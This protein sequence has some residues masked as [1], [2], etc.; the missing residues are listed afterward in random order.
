[1]VYFLFQFGFGERI[2]KETCHQSVLLR[3]TAS[4][5]HETMED[6]VPLKCKTAKYCITSRLIGKGKCPAF[7]GEEKEVT[8]VRVKSRKDI[9]RFLAREIIDCWEM[10]GEGKLNL[11]T[12]YIAKNFGFG[13]ISSTCVIC[14]R[15][16]FD[17]EALEKNKIDWKNLSVLEYMITHKIPDKNLTYYEYLQ[18]KGG[19]LNIKTDKIMQQIQETLSKINVDEKN[20]EVSIGNEEKTLQFENPTETENQVAIV[21]MQVIAPSHSEVLK[22]TVYAVAGGSAATFFLS[23]KRFIKA[24]TSAAFWKVALPIAALVGISQHVNVA[25]NRNVAFT[26]CSDVSLGDEAREGCTAIRLVPYN[27]EE[28]SQYCSIIES[29]P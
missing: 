15:I 8:K 21:F 22:N 4:T 2:N 29:I 10:M 12:D 23:P 17:Y 14:S 25:L 1:M 3:A 7:K 6:Y 20:E 9:E 5:L 19:K 16:D 11:F 27:P 24:V 28:I 26:K 18:G 13:G